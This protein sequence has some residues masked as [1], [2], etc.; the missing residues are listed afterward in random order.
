MKYYPDLE[1]IVNHLKKFSKEVAFSFQLNL[2]SSKKFDNRQRI[3]DSMKLSFLQRHFG[4]NIIVLDYAEQF[5]FYGHV[6]AAKEL[7]E[8]VR[9]LGESFDAKDICSKIANRFNCYKKSE[10]APSKGDNSSTTASASP[11]EEADLSKVDSAFNFM[12]YFG[13]S[14]ILALLLFVFI[15]DL[16]SNI[17]LKSRQNENI[18]SN[19]KDTQTYPP[20]S[21]TSERNGEYDKIR[22]YDTGER[23]NGK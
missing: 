10:A 17:E 2:L 1:D 22:L 19:Y 23:P 8:A 15:R 5:I 4:K 7:N 14:L 6:A 21:P 18:K 16:S 20:P 13:I 9:V 11:T 12:L 3:A